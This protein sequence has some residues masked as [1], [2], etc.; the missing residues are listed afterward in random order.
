[1]NVLNEEKVKGL[2]LENLGLKTEN[3]RLTDKV[4]V[5]EDEQKENRLKIAELEKKVKE[6]ELKTLDVSQFMTWNWE[7]IV[8]WI[9]SIG[10]GKFKKYEESLKAAMS[11][12][13]Y[14][15]EDLLDVTVLVIKHWGIKDRKD[16]VELN[17]FIQ[18]LVQQKGPNQG[19]AK[20]MA[21]AAPN[22]NEG[23]PTAFVG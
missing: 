4:S 2:E 11:E 16:R 5:Y 22:D 14:T 18:E 17:G 7:Q 21:A 12:E 19:G 20:M 13:E 15:G 3:K 1:M 8:F 23:A 6:L 9:I 10:D